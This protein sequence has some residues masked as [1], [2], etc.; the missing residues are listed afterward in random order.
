MLDWTEIFNMKYS[1]F[2]KRV[3][4]NNLMKIHFRKVGA[5]N[6]QISL[7]MKATNNYIKKGYYNGLA[8]MKGQKKFESYTLQQSLIEEDYD[9]E[10]S[11]ILGK[12]LYARWVESYGME[13]IKYLT[14]LVDIQSWEEEW[15]KKIFK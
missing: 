8:Y 9:Q 7:A 2:R 11:Q 4:G 3:Q 1:D 14:P 5:S 13:V 15:I 6:Y 12:E 10:L